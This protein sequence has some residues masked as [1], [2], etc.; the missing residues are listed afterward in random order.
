MCSTVHA[1]YKCIMDMRPRHDP[2][3]G[4]YAM[5]LVPSLR[6]NPTFQTGRRDNGNHLTPQTN[7][8]RPTNFII[9]NIRCA[10]NDN[11]KRNFREILDSHR[12]CLVTLIKTRMPN[13]L[14]LLNDFGFT[15]MIEVPIVGQVD[16]MVVL[17]D[18]NLVTVNNFVRRD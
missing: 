6:G 2:N 11:F 17:W 9:W 1:L 12:P 5:I 16:G 4:S 15:D 7:M 10:N 3:V 13:H 8:N 18:H 14:G